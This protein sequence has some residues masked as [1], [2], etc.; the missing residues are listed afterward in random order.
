MLV[1][2]QVTKLLQN[3]KYITSAMEVYLSV[4]VECQLV[5]WLSSMKFPG[6]SAPSVLLLCHSTHAA[7]TAWFK[8]TD[9]ASAVITKS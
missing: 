9:L 5:W 4:F 7:S 3:P 8:M 6:C 2:I 1:K